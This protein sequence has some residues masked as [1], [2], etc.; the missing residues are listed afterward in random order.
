MIPSSTSFL[1]RPFGSWANAEFSAKHS[2]YFNQMFDMYSK[3]FRKAALERTILQRK[4]IIVP[5][6]RERELTDTLAKLRKERNCAGVLLPREE[7]PERDLVFGE[8]QIFR[9]RAQRDNFVRPLYMH[10]PGDEGLTRCTMRSIK[11]HQRIELDFQLTLL[12]LGPGNRAQMDL[13]S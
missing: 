3:R 11:T 9:L 2:D 7:F 13:E 6:V 8:R 4:K 12:I 1:K 5:A 10:V